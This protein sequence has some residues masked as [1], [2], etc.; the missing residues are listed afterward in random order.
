[1]FSG[2]GRINKISIINKML[3]WI[4]ISFVEKSIVGKRLGWKEFLF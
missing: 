2:G 1:M 3:C 4:V